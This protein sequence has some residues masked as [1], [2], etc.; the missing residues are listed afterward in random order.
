MGCDA[1][2]AHYGLTDSSSSAKRFNSYSAR[3]DFRRQI[4]TSKVD[5]RTVRLK[6]FLMVVD[7]K[8]RYS[9]KSETAN[10]DN[11]DYFKL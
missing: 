2:A 4:L 1:L 9:N 3:I 11:Y 7:Q 5:P 10:L 6:I 8:H